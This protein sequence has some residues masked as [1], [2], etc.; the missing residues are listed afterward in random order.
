MKLPQLTQDAQVFFLINA[1]CRNKTKSISSLRVRLPNYDT[2][3]SAHTVS[4]NIPE[5]SEAASVA[6]VFPDMAN[7]L[8]ISVGQV[9]N[10]VYSVTFKIVGVAIINNKGKAILKGRVMQ[11]PACG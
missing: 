7:N 10:E 5:L 3:D 2:M 11:E 4:L 8:F 9:C 6:H 1:P